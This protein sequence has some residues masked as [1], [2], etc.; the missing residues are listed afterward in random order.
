MQKNKI[1]NNASWIIGCK[2][3]QSIVS[4]LVS[5]YTARYLGPSNYGLINYAASMV[6]FIT[7]LAQLGLG[8]IQVQELVNKPNKEGVTIGTTLILSLLSSFACIVGVIIF[9]FFVNVGETVT[10]IVVSLYSIILLFQGAELL[11]FWFQAHYISKYSSLTSFLAFLIV[12]IYRVVLLV[13]GASIYWFAVAN[14][15]DSF[16]VLIA[17]LYFLRYKGKVHLSFS[18]ITAKQLFEKSKYYILANMMIAVFTQTDRMMLK[19]MLSDSATGYYS[20]AA[21]F[22]GIANFVFVAIIDSA[23]PSIFEKKNSNESSYNNSL[24]SLYNVIIYITL[25]SSLLITV[26]SP[27]LIHLA[28]GKAYDPAISVL[29]ILA[30]YTTG[31]YLGAVRNVWVLAEGKQRYIWKVN[32]IGAVLIFAAPYVAS[33]IYSFANTNFK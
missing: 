8:N 30:W 13:K 33:A 5:I 1:V 25:F 2:I 22:A 32:L 28:Y 23:R 4:F 19:I 29:R 10:L 11:Q 7:P 15:F 27:Q 9:C 18:R 14:A 12:S 3:A 20:V 24:I 31:S 21:S 16:L 17:L 6:T 26:L